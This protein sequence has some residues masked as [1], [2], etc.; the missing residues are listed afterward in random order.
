MSV[1]SKTVGNSF[2][3]N[4][5]GAGRFAWYVYPG[6]IVAR[7]GFFEQVADIFLKV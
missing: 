1:G 5:G 4:R 2:S 6:I 3:G 7:L